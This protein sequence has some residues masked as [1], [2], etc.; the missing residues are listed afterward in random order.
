MSFELQ[1]D[2]RNFLLA[3]EWPQPSCTVSP[4][5][6]LQGGSKG[7]HYVRESGSQTLKRL[8]I[9]LLSARSVV[10]W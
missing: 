5:S 3:R 7:R 8:F 2:V 9:G 10:K 6:V 4:R 1:S